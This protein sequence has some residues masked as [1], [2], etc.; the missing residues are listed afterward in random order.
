MEGK[1]GK[2]SEMRSSGSWMWRVGRTFIDSAGRTC[3]C[4]GGVFC[5]SPAVDLVPCL[6]MGL[7]TDDVHES[8]VSKGRGMSR[9][10]NF[11]EICGGMTGVVLFSLE[12]GT[13][14]VQVEYS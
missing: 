2:G 12:P 10:L 14:R 11:V 6:L 7:A 9:A 5:I 1:F 4:S 8:G 13:L 3:T